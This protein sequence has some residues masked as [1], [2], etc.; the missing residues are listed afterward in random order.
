MSPGESRCSDSLK[1][2][3]HFLDQVAQLGDRGPLLDFGLHSVSKSTPCGLSPGPHHDPR[4]C[5]RASEVTMATQAWAPEP[6]G[7]PLYQHQLPLGVF[8]GKMLR[9]KETV[10]L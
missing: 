4:D 1:E 7:P 10:V 3:G 2:N 6:L 9:G 8:P 5:C